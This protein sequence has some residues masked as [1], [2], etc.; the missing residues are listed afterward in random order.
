MHKVQRLPWTLAHSHGQQG[1]MQV[2][3][4]IPEPP[5]PMPHKTP[6]TRGMDTHPNS[7]HFVSLAVCFLSSAASDAAPIDTCDFEGLLGATLLNA[8]NH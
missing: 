4:R 2:W 6:T 1:E 3:K 5:C 7:A 8:Q